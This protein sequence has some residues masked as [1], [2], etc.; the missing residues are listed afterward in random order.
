MRE[1]LQSGV[2]KKK[3]GIHRDLNDKRLP[4]QDSS[5]T[6]CL[7][8][9][10]F[11]TMPSDGK[12]LIYFLLRIARYISQIDRKSHLLLIIFNTQTSLSQNK[13]DMYM[14]M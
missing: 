5:H 14:Y 13:K 4:C 9:F 10:R 12:S 6:P 2:D 7:P 8:S 11:N 3:K 1:P